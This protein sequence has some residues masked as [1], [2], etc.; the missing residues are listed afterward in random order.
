M[1]KTIIALL[2]SPLE[3]NTALLLDQAIAGAKSVGSDV[4]RYHVPLLDF[5]PCM[6][7]DFC[8]EYPTCKMDDD[9]T[10]LMPEF[11]RAN[12]FI[13]ATP[14]M[15]MGVPGGLKSFM[16]RFHVFF[17]AKFL[18]NAPMVPKDLRESRKTLVISISGM[19][20]KNNFDCLMT[21][22][23]AYCDTIDAPVMDTLFVKDMDNIIDINTRPEILKEA[24]D[25]GVLLA[26]AI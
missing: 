13:I 16:D 2:G 24:H 1:T 15:T 3:G 22:V 17:N 9:V 14:V 23:R 11:A 19:N 10:R 7:I 25:K 4:V 18:R 5:S 20:L 8:K 6:R 21:T 26:H 12:G